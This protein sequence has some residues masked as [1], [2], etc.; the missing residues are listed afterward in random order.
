MQAPLPWRNWAPSPDRRHAVILASALLG[1]AT[2]VAASTLVDAERG[3]PVW[4]FLK[5]VR[6]LGAYQTFTVPSSR[7]LPAARCEA[8][9]GE[10]VLFDQADPDGARR[11]WEPLAKTGDADAQYRM[12]QVLLVEGPSRDAK[13]A[14]DWLSRAAKAGHRAAMLR[15][16]TLYEQGDGLARDATEA[17]RWYRMAHG[18]ADVASSEVSA[19]REQLAAARQALA[20]AARAA[21]EAK[22]PGGVM[23][24]VEAGQLRLTQALS[25]LPAASAID[26]EP[27]RPRVILFDPTVA[28]TRAA[29]VVRLAAELPSKIVF[30]RVVP[31]R[32]VQSL[33]VNGEAVRFD[34]AGFF[35]KSVALTGPRTRV[36]AVAL[37]TAGQPDTVTVFLERGEG[38]VDAAPQTTIR[39]LQSG[40]TGHALLIG[41]D[42]YRDSKIQRL[43]TALADSEAVGRLLRDKYGFRTRVLANATFS[44]ILNALNEMVNAVGPAD[45]VLIYY[46]GHGEIE[47][48]AGSRGFR[49]NWLP[50]DASA[51]SNTLWISSAKVADL[52]AKMRARKVLIVSDSCYSGAM[53]AD[54]AVPR[55]L[56]DL[57]DAL[58]G[59]AINDLQRVP[60]R[61]ML[62]SGSFAPVLD[63]AIRGNSVFARALLDVLSEQ[64]DPIEGLRLAELVAARVTRAAASFK[65][66]NTAAFEQLPLYA[67]LDHAGHEG[68]DFIFFPM[69]RK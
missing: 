2:T 44:Q 17:N 30:G 7:L 13:L 35:S 65:A 45:S 40:G 24:R 64:S 1:L 21:G 59:A 67:A 47:R 42:Q 56:D 53:A 34:S 39:T 11:L 32:E 43:E 3:T 27:G 12:G 37:G 15:L 22:S 58:R 46:A 60:S 31:V 5:Q 69:S 48:F 20:E 25:G 38:P 8:V 68:G 57:P 26:G 19:L 41:N 54:G 4:C 29:N 18:I 52:A 62:T 61:T 23:D 51:A 63:E 28:R 14:A 33:T 16:A 6:K 50:V 36:Q 55:L 9:G 10:Y 66:S 49:G